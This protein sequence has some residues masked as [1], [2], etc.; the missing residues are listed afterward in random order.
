MNRWTRRHPRRKSRT[1]KHNSARKFQELERRDLLAGD[2]FEPN[3]SFGDARPLTSTITPDID[4]AGDV[5]FFKWRAPSS[6]YV[7]FDVLFS[8]ASGD[9]DVRL[10]DSLEN[11]IDASIS[12]DDNER[13]GTAVVANQEVFVQISEFS[14]T[15]TVDYTLQPTFIRPDTFE[16]NNSRFSASNLG[17]GEK[18]IS[19]LNIHNPGDRDYYS[20]TA[21][22]DGVVTVS[23]AFSHF[24]GDLSLRVLTASGSELTS[25]ETKTDN[26]ATSLNVVAG[27]TY[28]IEV[29]ESGGQEQPAYTLGVNFNSPPEF[30]SFPDG[31]VLGPIGGTT[32]VNFSVADSNNPL[33]SLSITG[34][35]TDK[36]LVPD[37][38]ISFFGSGANRQAV[39]NSPGGFGI[40][41]ITITVSDPDGGSVSQTFPLWL[42]TNNASPPV[43]SSIGDITIPENG[44]SSTLNF[45]VNDAETSPNNLVVTATSSNTTVVPNT[46]DNIILSGAG[47]NRAIRIRPALNQTGTTVI[48]VRVTD[49]D[50]ESSTTSFVVTVF[51]SSDAPT[52]TQINDVAI[53]R[54]SSTGPIPFTIGDPDTSVFLLNVTAT[55]S[56]PSIVP[57]SG[58]LVSG[59]GASR[60][61]TVTP[62]FTAS[63][64]ATITVAVSDGTATTTESFNVNIGVDNAPPSIG[65]IPDRTI[66]KNSS[67]PTTLFTVSDAETNPNNLVVTAASNNPFLLPVSNI[68][69]GGAGS[70][71]TVSATP[72][73]GRQGAAIIT[74][75]VTDGEGATDEE[76]F[77]LIVLGDEDVPGAYQQDGGANNI[78]SIEA[79]NFDQN[80]PQ[81]FHAWTQI[82]DAN[83]TLGQAMQTSPNVGTLNDFGFVSNSPRLDFDV[84]FVRTGTH[85]IWI[86]GSAPQ[87]D[88]DSNDSVHIGL[89]GI[90]VSTADRITGFNSSYGWSNATMDGIV[91]T[92]FVSTT[93]IH[94]INAWM[95]E[96][97]FIL[98]KVVL[99]SSSSYTPNAQGPPESPRLTN[100][101]VAVDDSFSTGEGVTLN[102]PAPGVL[103]NDQ[104]PSSASLTVQ[105]VVN[106]VQNGFLTLNPNGSFRYIPNSNFR[107]TDSFTYRA[108]N[109]STSSNVATVTITVGSLIEA[110][111]NFGS[112]G[113]T[114]VD[115]VFRG[116][117]SPDYASGT[118]LPTGGLTGGGLQV[119]LGGIDDADVQGMSGGW[120]RT[121]FLATPADVTISVR[122]NLSQTT[123]YE[124]DEFSQALLSVDGTLYGTPPNTYMDELTGNGNGG[125]DQ[126]TGWESFTVKIGA[127]SA[128]THTLTVGGYNNQKTTSDESTVI[129]IDD[130]VVTGGPVNNPPASENDTYNTDEDRPLVV[131][132]ADGVLNN[133]SDSDGDPIRVAEVVD[134]VNNGT[135]TLNPDGSFIYSPKLGFNGVDTFTYQATDEKDL[136]NVATVRIAVGPIND[137][138][139][140]VGDSYDAVAG[141]QLA[142][143]AGAG[144]LSNDTDADGDNLTV[145]SLASGVNNGSLILNSDGS[146]NYT[147]N[148]GFDGIDSFSYVATDGNASSNVATVNISVTDSNTAPVATDDSY[149][150][151]QPILDVNVGSGVLA[152]DTDA[153]GNQLTAV[154]VTAPANGSLTLRS[155]GSLQYIPNV[156]FIGTDSFTYAAFDGT[157]LSTPATVTIEITAPLGDFNNDLVVDGEDLDLMGPGIYE[158][159]P[160]FDLNGDGDVNSTDFEIFITDIFPV[161]IGDSNL[162]RQFDSGDLV[163][164][165]QKGEYEDGVP[166]NSGW[167]AGDWNGDGD[168]NSQDIIVAFQ[169][170]MFGKGV[171][172]ARA[173]DIASALNDAADSMLP[174]SST[175]SA[176]EATI[177]NLPLRS[178]HLEETAQES[179]FSEDEFVTELRLA[180]MEDTS[181]DDSECIDD[182]C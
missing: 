103:S 56:N 113:F 84:N 115:D 127:L 102:V 67:M 30:T 136:G 132:V 83:A 11:Q 22:E 87:P 144:V 74:L 141:Q 36:L 130:I 148:A 27:T 111:F 48:T 46:D 3:N 108:T 63:G 135:L 106:N 35:S 26:E 114:Y 180:S 121:F 23:A 59:F 15:R 182:W 13:V 153:D 139:V 147:P 133:D 151:S 142:V 53:D 166:G 43:I 24:D 18:S 167:S 10:Y 80:V 7:R 4:P 104:D 2:V 159:D 5:D 171:I 73:A 14:G 76:T 164:V 60:T 96:D 68:F 29:F 21:T 100:A 138:P 61:V 77:V 95:R 109:G 119:E 42:F 101:P 47:T 176:A 25:S 65:F 122:Y 71:R 120:Q 62:L 126:S 94:T 99:T 78:V 150:L 110:N 16:P 72:V 145:A 177:A 70:T 32:L 1:T 92:V 34:S 105:S 20:W 116:T 169:A 37:A 143:P 33:S 131:N 172:A 40:T 123:G 146:F 149:E 117:N 44:T 52:I 158:Q 88:S 97:G 86:R 179:L 157:V 28:I 170:D 51:D 168:F 129:L 125:S 50:S 155:D 165:F 98:D 31:V 174:R 66:Q 134:D 154:E 54:G 39:I 12:G 38:N 118:Y 79:N 19:G 6:G 8:H 64:T 156:G 89:N 163:Q 58:I 112:D 161:V 173:A 45:S 178:T 69:L 124:S 107:G 91:A 81:G 128:G 55:S 57:N 9:I 75:T 82:S 93:G 160:K 85:Y 41:N 140:A 49:D 17:T 175:V 90:A 137:A 181:D 152:N 162:D